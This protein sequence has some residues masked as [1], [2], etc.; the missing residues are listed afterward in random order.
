MKRFSLF[1][2]PVLILLAAQ[3]ADACTSIRIKTTD[4]LV[5]YA[6]TME[7]GPKTLRP[8]HWILRRI[9]PI[10]PPRSSSKGVFE[11]NLEARD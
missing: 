5:F 3:A 1:C 11:I 9:T 4:S 8:C 7:G 2:G 10:L 6:R